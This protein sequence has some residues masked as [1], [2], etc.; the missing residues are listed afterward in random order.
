MKIVI[1]PDSFK[2]S[3]TNAQ[4]AK[5]LCRAV[6]EVY[7]SA[8]TV[9]LPISDGGEGA[10]EVLASALPGKMYQRIVRGPYGRSVEASY[11]LSDA[12]LGV[13]ELAQAAGLTLTEPQERFPLNA[14]TFG[15]GE[16]LLDAL[17]NGAKQLCLT[18]GGSATND[19]GAG[20]AQALGILLLDA[21]GKEIEPTCAGL[22]RLQS[23]DASKQNSALSKVPL[24][25]ACDVKNPLC[26]PEGASYIY[27]PQKGA[28]FETAKEMD[29]IL[30]RY[31]KLLSAAAGKRGLGQLP[32][33][34]AAG[35]A[36]LPLLAFY[37]ARLLSGVDMVLDAL[38]FEEHLKGAALVLTGEGKIDSQTKYGKAI[39]GVITRARKAKVPVAAFAGALELAPG[40]YAENGVSFY[41]INPPGEQLAD[42]MAQAEEHLQTVCAKA[43]KELL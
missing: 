35:G 2:G 7:P 22:S 6:R 42:S 10:A 14:T 29:G 34:G 8:E 36:A 40:D 16:L 28:D 23:V 18:L 19:G 39:H 13:V 24:S 33:S 27:G 15:V 20:I 11:F 31:E 9:V 5:A 43:L 41:R 25:I 4:A 12:G 3:L 38:K 21:A 26:G 1:A 17:K 32:G 37:E 30:C